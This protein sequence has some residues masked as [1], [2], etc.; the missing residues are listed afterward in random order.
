MH[1]ALPIGPFN[2]DLC[3]VSLPK[4]KAPLSSIAEENRQKQTLAFDLYPTLAA[5]LAFLFSPA[6]FVKINIHNV[7]S[8]ILLI[9]PSLQF[10]VGCYT[11]GV[12]AY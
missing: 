1:L 2:V 12:S 11:L 3:T 4:T 8:L 5:I 10:D 7:Y 6:K 9:P